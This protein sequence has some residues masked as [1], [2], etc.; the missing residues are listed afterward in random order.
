MSGVSRST[1][2]RVINEDPNVNERTRKRVQDVIQNLNF[3]PNLAA[4]SLAA[5]R[6]GVL[7]LVIPMGVSAIFSDPFFPL[8]IQGVSTTCNA[9]DYSVMLWLAEPEYERRT[10]RQILYNGL[11]DGVIVAS[12]LT[13][14]TII[15]RLAEGRLP[16][17]LTGRHPTRPQ[18]NYV[19][20]DNRASSRNL[21]MYLFR[22]GYSR[23]AMITGPQNMIAGMDRFLGYQ[24]AYEEIGRVI[25]LDLV[26]TGDFTDNSG[27]FAMRRLLQRKPDAVFAGSDPMALGALRAI[28]EAGLR[29]PEDIAVVGFDDLPQSAKASP[30]LTTV[31]QPIQRSGARAA[32]LLIDIILHPETQPRHEILPT[33][34]VIRQS[35][36]GLAKRR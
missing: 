34:L 5:G 11:V 18:L 28:Q 4:R 26:E 8:F 13:D 15:E 14:D 7:G 17:V 33:E 36:G 20:V 3:Q 30:P 2:S 29:I 32:E 25:D 22:Q 19:D 12:M 9:L 31:R 6:T 10:I 21:V 35:C 27:Y 24:D 23:V 16:F 1:V